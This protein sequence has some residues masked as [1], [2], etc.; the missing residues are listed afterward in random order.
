MSIKNISLNFRK[1]K[2]KD[3]VVFFQNL[4]VMLKSGL[5]ITEALD[6]IVA[7]TSGRLGRI[8][9]SVSNKVAAGNTL[10][11]S[12]RDYP[13]AF[14][15][16]IVN[17]LKAGEVSGNLDESLENIA[18][19]LNKEKILRDKVRGAMV[20]PVIVLI[21]SLVVGTV[22]SVVVLPKITPIFKGLKIDLPVS[23][24]ILIW[25]ADLTGR[26]GALIIAGLAVTIFFIGWLARQEFIRP[27]TNRLFLQL[28]L[29]NRITKNKNLAQ[30]SQLLGTLTKSGLSLDETLRITAESVN[31]HVYRKKL[32]EIA[33]DVSGGMKLSESLGRYPQLFPRLAVSLVRVGE[34]SGKL[35]E[36]FFNLAAIYE[37]EVDNATKI[38]SILVEPALLLIIGLA[39]GWLALSIISPIYQI[40]GNIY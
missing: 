40:T 10:S 3:K 27:A 9:K 18:V 7:Q 13:K 37:Q 36:E 21:M 6:I 15:G 39:V 30:A 17:A 38:L 35:E 25:L 5:T 14:A 26:H 16:F 12:L 4:A 1:V 11:K 20:Y 33:Q 34:Q 32:Y 19:Q 29:I 31:N 28:P 24:R 2:L 22:V 23:T 8:V